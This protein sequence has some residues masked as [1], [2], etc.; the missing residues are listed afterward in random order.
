MSKN[1]IKSLRKITVNNEPYIWTVTDHNCD[2]DGSCRFK[3]WKNKVELYSE[4]VSS[5]SITPKIVRE[6]IL[7]INSL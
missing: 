4:L 2:G 5:V 6:K 1:R 3:I 7:E